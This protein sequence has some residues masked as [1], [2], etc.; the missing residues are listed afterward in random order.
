MKVAEGIEMLTLDIQGFRLHPVL[1]WDEE[2]A[3][4]VDTGM[5]GR[6]PALREAM[7]AAGVP[8]EHLRTVIVTHQ[9]LDHIGGLPELR[10][11]A[12]PQLRVLAHELERPYIEG[13]L[14]L[15]KTDPA[16]MNKAEWD[17]LPEPM[18]QLYLH[19]PRSRVDGLLADGEELPC[20]G[21]IRV[22][23]TPGHTPGHISLYVPRAKLLIAADA[24]TAS[25]GVLHGP[26][27]RN[28]PDMETAR[29]SIARLQ[30][31]ELE[32]VIC[33]HGGACRTDLQA[34]LR[35]LAGTEGGAH[36]GE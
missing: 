31:L 4:L 12:G 6:L 35:Q 1:L 33:Y 20:A 34:R 28:T 32:T 19:P 10:E 13:E 9:D 21:G 23:A 3:V 11:A 29:R 2:G 14:P 5:P 27:S 7:E 36:D 15:L 16:R 17:A 18:R 30:E 22:V 25:N 8:L 26:V 24:L